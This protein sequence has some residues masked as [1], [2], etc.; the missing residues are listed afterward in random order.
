MNECKWKSTTLVSH[1]DLNTLLST[2]DITDIKKKIKEIYK[3]SSE[4]EFQKIT[5]GVANEVF[6]VRHNSQPIA[7]LKYYP[8]N[9]YKQVTKIYQFVNTLIEHSI[10][11]ST[12]DYIYE[13]ER[14]KAALL[15][16]YYRGYHAK[17]FSP[18]QQ[19]EVVKA[20]VKIHMLEI[21]CE[22]N[23]DLFEKFDFLFLKCENWEYTKKIE[24]HV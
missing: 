13:T 8:N 11:T 6:L 20:M 5:H 10:P 17:I 24:E 4:V 18:E 12:P 15:L 7:V 22:I 21:P 1:D 19:N 2:C 16:P 14:H 23:N 9:S 3:N